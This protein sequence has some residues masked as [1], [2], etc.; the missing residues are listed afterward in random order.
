[1]CDNSAGPEGP[2]EPVGAICFHPGA[3]PSF[4]RWDGSPFD[5]PGA[6]PNPMQYLNAISPEGTRVAVGQSQLW[7]YGPGGRAERLNQSGYVMGW[8]DES[9]IVIQQ[10]EALL[11]IE[12]HDFTLQTTAEISQGVASYLGTFPAA[13]V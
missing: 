7:I 3:A 8:L 11:V 9:H 4:Q 13:V 1:M 2:I 10:S 6:V 12:V 5:F